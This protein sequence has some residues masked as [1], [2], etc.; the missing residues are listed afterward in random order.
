MAE[1]VAVGLGQAGIHRFNV[2]HEDQ[3]LTCAPLTVV[4]LP[5]TEQSEQSEHSERG[6]PAQTNPELSPS[7]SSSR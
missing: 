3:W 7:D 4:H 5:T 1:R 6:L 2:Y